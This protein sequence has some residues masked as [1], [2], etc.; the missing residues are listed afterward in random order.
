MQ[1]TTARL[2]DSVA[3]LCLVR[4]GIQVRRVGGYFYA[5]KLGRAVE[6]AAREAIGAGVGLLLS[7]RFGLGPGDFGFFQYWQGFEAMET[8][9]RK[10]PHS[11]WWRDA[12]E[13]MRTRGDLGVYHETY[14]VPR[15]RVEAIAL[16]CRPAGLAAFG[17]AGE[18]VGADTN[19]R[20]RLQLGPRAT[21]QGG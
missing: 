12:V 4:M 19:G 6:A 17:T 15:D 20:G 7:E 8:W 10:P 5:R 16:N 18:P 2:P 1:R 3:E 13:R 11:E 9:T 21:G 14:L